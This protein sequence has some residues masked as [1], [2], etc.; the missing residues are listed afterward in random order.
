MPDAAR[1]GSARFRRDRSNASS[2]AAHDTSGS[3]RSH[4]PDRIRSRARIGRFAPAAARNPAPARDRRRV[5]SG[6]ATSAAFGSKLRISGCRPSQSPSATYGGLLTIT[7]NGPARPSPQRP[8]RKSAR[9]RQAKPPGIALSDRERRGAVVDPEPGRPRQLGQQREQQATGADAEVEQAQRPLPIGQ[10]R[11]HR[12]DDR[13]GLGPRDQDRRANLKTQ[14]PEFLLAKEVGDRF[15]REAASYQRIQARLLCGA[16]RVPRRPSARRARPRSQRPAT[17]RPPSA[18]PRCPPRR[19]A[20]QSERL[21][22]AASCCASVCR[23]HFD[24]ITRAQARRRSARI[25]QRAW[26]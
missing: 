13:L 15:A 17:A 1:A 12:L 23:R 19:D 9:A 3:R 22:H 5:P 18:R 14:A 24:L 25:V 10:L 7:S 4:R 20:P 6:P 8:C 16:Q 2:R 26:P 21:D 11:Q